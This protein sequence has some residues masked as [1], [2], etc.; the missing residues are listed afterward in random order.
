MS[1]F[2]QKLGFKG[3]LTAMLVSLV[4][5]S[6]LIVATTVFLEYRSSA[7]KANA[8]NLTRTGQ[9]VST[10]FAEWIEARQHEVR[11]AA[12]LPAATELNLDTLASIT[13]NLANAQGFYDTIYVVDLNGTGLV[14]ASHANGRA[15]RISPSEAASFKVSDRDWFKQAAQG[16]DVI[17][18]P[19]VSRS[20]GNRVSNVVVPIRKN[21]NVV[22]VFRAAVKLDHITNEVANLNID[23]DPNVF[24]VDTTG[25]LITPSR[26][27][28]DMSTPIRTAASEQIANGR[29]GLSSYKNSQ[30]I[31]VIGN[32]NYLELL[33]WGL[34]IEQTQQHAMAEVNRMFW[35]VAVI[36]LI[37]IT[38]SVL[39]SLW[40]TNGVIKT[41]GGEPSYATEIVSAVAEGDLTQNINLAG[42]DD[43]SLLA[44]IGRM[45]RQLRSI[46]GDISSY[47]EQVAASATQLSQ[48]SD[49]TE[50]GIDRQN[51]Q[52]NLAAT[53][54]NEMSTTSAEVARNAQEAASAA[55]RTNQEAQ[56]GREAV[57]ATINSVHELDL[58]IQ[59]TS[60][61]IDGLKA[62]SDQIGQVLTVIETIAEQTNLLALN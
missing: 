16:N 2:S 18:S 11:F 10:S 26:Y 43:Q 57:T 35:V 40:I 19:L 46:M 32:S 37:M 56:T 50:A 62:D 39:I 59:N 48:I 51:E 8:S 25:Q 7:I 61:I 41:L 6:V 24:L 28:S 42:A 23:G 38:I 22:A 60:S 1:A 12:Q 5:A 31:N 55:T 15:T 20:T 21:G 54:V 49:S 4:I 44:A 27:Q 47:S 30:G 58:E 29:S 9:Y 14:G 34:I 36:V 53:A 13:F 3:R 52:L 45:Q 33:G 17:S